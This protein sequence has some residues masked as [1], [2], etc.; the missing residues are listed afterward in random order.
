MHFNLNN[1]I[2]GRDKY[3][4][5]HIN[6]IKMRCKICSY[7]L[8]KF[9]IMGIVFRNCGEGRD[10]IPDLFVMTKSQFF[11]GC[12]PEN[13][14]AFALKRPKSKSR[15][16]RVKLFCGAHRD[17]NTEQ[18]GQARDAIEQRYSF[19][20]RLNKPDWTAVAIDL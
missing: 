4:F 5:F 7:F 9:W 18:I 20:V 12:R 16:G 10:L 19:R 2:Y 3:F 11:R 13:D 15:L 14:T 6:E 1:D 17:S 8:L